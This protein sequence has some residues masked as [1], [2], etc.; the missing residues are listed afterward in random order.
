MIAAGRAAS[1]TELTAD[2][3][4]LAYLQALRIAPGQRDPLPTDGGAGD[5]GVSRRKRIS[6]HLRFVGGGFALGVATAG[7]IL[8]ILRP[9][10]SVG[11]DA[12]PIAAPIVAKGKT[13]AAPD[14][15]VASGY[16]VARRQATVAAEVTGRITSL[17]FEEGQAV[18]AGAVLAA[19][20]DRI[21]RVE[22]EMVMADQGRARAA[23]AAVTAELDDARSSYDRYAALHGRGFVSDASL[24]TQAAR[25]ASLQA[26][27]DGARAER[28]A[29]DL[30]ARKLHEQLQYYV[31][32]APFDGVVIGRNAQVGEIISPVSAGNGFTRTGI[33]TLVDMS[34]LEIA[35]DVS[36]RQIAMVAVG[37]DVVAMLDAYPMLRLP[38][39]VL[40]IIPAANRDKATV[41]VRIGLRGRD[42][43]ILPN[44]AAKVKFL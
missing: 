27:L 26:R 5:E 6:P 10:A 12:G 19:L 23:V 9:H 25:R 4:R 42:A 20:D 14:M 43:R 28:A 35:V 24:S 11:A 41:T 30:R 29:A 2:Q 17:H 44:M 18:K 32:R 3:A 15:L 1:V 8:P 40:G 33:C 39:K 36:E 16:V 38:A 21:A 34:S 7:L 31:I 22:H 13:G 37:D